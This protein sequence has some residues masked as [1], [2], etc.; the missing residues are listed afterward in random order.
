MKSALRKTFR[1]LLTLF[2]LASFGAIFSLAAIYLYLSPNL[3]SVKS[4]RDV[5]LQTPLRVYSSDGLLIGEFGEKR[6]RPIK[7]ENVPQAFIDALLAAEDRDFYSHKGVSIRGLARAVTELITTGEKGSGGSTLTMQLT[8]N[9]FLSLDIKFVRKFNEILLS[10]KLERELTKDEILELYVNYMFLGKRAYGIQAAAEVYYGTELSELSLAQLA[11]IA[12]LFQGPS[13][14]NPIINPVRALERRNWILRQMYSLELVDKQQFESALA[15]PITAEYHGSRLDISAPYVA[16]LA[17]EKAIRTFGLKAYTDGYRVITTVNSEMQL[18]AQEAVV[19]G[20]MSYDKR[21]G[22]RGPELKLPMEQAP[23]ALIR[24]IEAEAV[25][26]GTNSNENTITPPDSKPISTDHEP[27]AQQTEDSPAW[28]LT[29]N[30]IPSYAG[31]APGVVLFVEDKRAHVL[32]KEGKR[33]TLEWED[34]LSSARPYINENARGASPQSASEVVS[35]GDVIRVRLNDELRW[36]LS[37]IP[38]VQA[39]LVA[40]KPK[41]GAILSVVGGFDFYENQFNRATQAY[42]Q[43][44]SGLKPF[45]YSAA[46]ENGMTAASIINDSPVVLEDAGYEGTWRPKNDGNKFYGPLRLRKALY[47]S[48]N[49]VSVKLV[50]DHL[51]IEKTR[52]ALARFGFNPKAL[53]SDVTL[54]LG[55]ASVTPLELG[56][57]WAAFANGGYKVGAHLIARIYDNDGRIIYEAFPDSVCN[58]CDESPADNTP[59]SA[60]TASDDQSPLVDTQLDPAIDPDT[61]KLPTTLK[62]ALGWLEPADYPRAPKVMNDQIAFI[63]DSVLKDVIT[64]GT[65]TRARVLNRPDLAGKTGTTNGPVDVWFSG[66]NQDIV[67]TTWV[68]FDQNKELGN[69]EFGSTAALPIWIDF[70]KTALKSSPIQSRI[71]PPG[72]VSIKIDLD[73]GERAQIDD[74]DAEFEYFRSEYVPEEKAESAVQSEG[75][76]LEALSEDIF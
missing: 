1:V 41:N 75:R 25:T 14:Q 69:N 3:P 56:T 38:E 33:I 23:L 40:L 60:N 15:E 72:I 13:T 51:G 28:Q 62:R 43:P 8:R 55:N 45:I 4:I 44:G 22:Y 54:S 30:E 2:A 21:H 53:P 24:E 19:N 20:L 29:L 73:T 27:I 52:S 66:Y 37:Q 5:R 6:R 17:R 11:M 39:A 57:A 61:F 64:R 76:P 70:M 32:L 58:D 48:R 65:G 26:N 42:R 36:Q 10:L 18:A 74:P 31:L 46:L 9:V 59:E 67:A 49:L 7:L 63:M 35:V 16:E 12:G 47:L 34:G 68:G 71:Q 50:K